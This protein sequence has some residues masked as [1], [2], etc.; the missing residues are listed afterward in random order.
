MGG[1]GSRIT[2]LALSAYWRATKGI[3]SNLLDMGGNVYA[4]WPFE[5][6]RLWNPPT[7]ERDKAGIA[8]QKKTASQHRA[9]T[10]L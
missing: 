5:E 10:T 4:L 6:E 7:K 3:S 8:W 9:D 1:R 2:P